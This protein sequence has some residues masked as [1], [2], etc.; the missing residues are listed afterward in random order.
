M[1]RALLI[2]LLIISCD[3]V[4][5]AGY[6]KTSLQ[7][8]PELWLLEKWLSPGVA[9]TLSRMTSYAIWAPLTSAREGKNAAQP[10]PRD[11]AFRK[12]NAEFCDYN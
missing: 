6:N 12:M 4:L 11:S 1:F 3:L 5:A 2:I 7:V 8:E 9:E 10:V